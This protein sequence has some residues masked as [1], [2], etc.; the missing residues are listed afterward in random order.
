MIYF[1]IILQL[2]VALLGLDYTMPSWKILLPSLIVI[3]I[4]TIITAIQNTKE[5]RN[6]KKQVLKI[7]VTQEKQNKH[8]STFIKKVEKIYSINFIEMKAMIEVKEF[9]NITSGFNL[10]S[11]TDFGSGKLR[12]SFIDPFP[13]I[14]YNTKIKSNRGEVRCTNIKKEKQNL[15]I[16][17]DE[18]G[19]EWVQVLCWEHLKTA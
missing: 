7:E 11:V 16:E 12:L 8:F 9:I 2:F 14:L 5:S 17:F 4:L 18:D 6:I 10:S 13:D 1:L 19:I 15:L 3:S